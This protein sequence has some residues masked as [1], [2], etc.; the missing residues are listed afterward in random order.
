MKEWK[1]VNNIDT[2]ILIVNNGRDDTE[3]KNR[4]AQGRKA[5]KRLNSIWWSEGITGSRKYKWDTYDKNLHKKKNLIIY[6][7]IL[8][9]FVVS[10]L[11]LSLK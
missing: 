6:V 2:G 5:V 8:K 9:R 3:I 10:H 1:T 4:I 11:P 7:F